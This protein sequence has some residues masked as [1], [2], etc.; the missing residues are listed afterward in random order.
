M[1]KKGERKRVEDYRGVT[2][3]Q[4]A[5]KV[6]VAV[7]AKRLREEVEE[8][9]L[10]PPNQAGFRK[11]LGIIDNIYVLNYLINRQINREIERL[12]VFFVDLRAAF[13]SV[14]VETKC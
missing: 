1:I 13:D 7:L 9:G 10:L 2:L 12:M 11:R 5:Y 3:T 8:R 6:Y 4:T 14:L